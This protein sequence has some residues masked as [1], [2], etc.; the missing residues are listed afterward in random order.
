MKQQDSKM[1]KAWFKKGDDDL[2]VAKLV[3]KDG[4]FMDIVGYHLNQAIEKYLKG[5]LLFYNQ[6]YPR[7]H[8]LVQLLR[9]CSKF[10]HDIIDYSEDCERM[11]TYYIEA[12]YPMDMPWNYPKDEMRKSI[13]M[14]EFLIKYIQKQINE[15]TT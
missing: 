9:E 11:N 7:T 12:K 5:F 4:G 3:F 8:N 15:Q 1:H 13:E 14:T 6:A 2:E 10:D